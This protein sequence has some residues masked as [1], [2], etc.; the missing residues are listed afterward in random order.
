MEVNVEAK[1]P[2]NVCAL[3]TEVKDSKQE[4]AEKGLFMLEKAKIGDRV[5]V[6]AGEQITE[7]EARARDSQYI[8]RVKEGVYL[9]AEKKMRRKGRFINHAGPGT[10]KNKRAM[11]INHSQEG[12]NARRRNID[13]IS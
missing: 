13:S 10:A 11:R 4:G 3:N 7:E 2:T 1:S 12:Y 5:A 8:L 9:D 6:Y